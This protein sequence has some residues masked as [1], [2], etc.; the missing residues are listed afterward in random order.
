[1]VKVMLKVMVE[2]WLQLLASTLFNQA[3]TALRRISTQS[4]RVVF[5]VGLEKSGSVININI[6][7]NLVVG[8]VDGDDDGEGDGAD[9]DDGDD[10][11]GWLIAAK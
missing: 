3:S 7:T 2:H 11:D 9:G 8:V 4:N 1:M 10:E 5:S 6:D